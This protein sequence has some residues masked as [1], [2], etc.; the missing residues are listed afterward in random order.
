[1]GPVDVVRYIFEEEIAEFS[2]VAAKNQEMFDTEVTD[3]V[4]TW[5]DSQSNVPY[6]NYY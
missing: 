6:N 4:I 1:M 2:K 5:A 3:R